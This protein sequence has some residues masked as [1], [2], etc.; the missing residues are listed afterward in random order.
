[1]QPWKTFLKNH[2]SD[3][4]ATDFFTVPT[5]TFNLLYVLVIVHHQSRKIIHFGVK[6]NPTAEWTIQQF[7][8]ATPYG[9]VPKYL[10]H[11]ND[12]IFRSKAF[13]RFLSSS[14]IRSKRTAYRFPLAK[15][16]S[17]N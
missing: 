14:D 10:I 16:L 5:L 17:M 2:Q 4:W 15:Q 7:R 3:T 9:D 13:Q 8:N 12:T 11:D 6:T 1:M